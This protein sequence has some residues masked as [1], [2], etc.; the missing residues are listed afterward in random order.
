M[1]IPHMP[2][3]DKETPDNAMYVRLHERG[4]L[5]ADYRKE[6]ASPSASHRRIAREIR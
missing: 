3:E 4:E 2:H 5:F 6:V 1:E